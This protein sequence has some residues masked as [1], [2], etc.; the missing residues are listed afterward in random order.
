MQFTPCPPACTSWG[1]ITQ[2]LPPRQ[3]LSGTAKPRGEGISPG[4]LV[5]TG[6]P[7]TPRELMGT[8][9]RL[10]GPT[11]SCCES[12]QIFSPPRD[13]DG[14]SF[15]FFSPAKGRKLQPCLAAGTDVLRTS[16]PF[17]HP[18]ELQEKSCS[19]SRSIPHLQ[20]MSRAASPSK[21]KPFRK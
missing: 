15:P 2:L 4:G 17:Q 21:I 8:R 19:T 9:H 14:D 1:R 13:G 3:Q 6:G 11:G 20:K 12:R 18:L 16:S 5:G 10:P 7:Q